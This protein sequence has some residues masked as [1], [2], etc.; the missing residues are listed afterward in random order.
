MPHHA[1]VLLID[2]MFDWLQPSPTRTTILGVCGALNSSTCH[3]AGL[4][5]TCLSHT[6]IPNISSGQVRIAQ[7]ST[8]EVKSRNVLMWHSSGGWLHSLGDNVPLMSHVQCH[9]FV[10]KGA[11]EKNSE[12]WE[13]TPFLSVEE[14]A[15]SLQITLLQYK[16][17]YCGR[18]RVALSLPVL[19]HSYQNKIWN[20][21]GQ[22]ITV[23]THWP[24]SCMVLVWGNSTSSS[25]NVEK[26]SKNYLKHGFCS[27]K[28]CFEAKGAL[29][30][31]LGTK[32]S[33]VH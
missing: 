26:I 30:F 9:C 13:A 33:W 32:K 23:C 28:T 25:E 4:H 14:R 24:S 21:S 5:F 29:R 7:L 16:D 22:E 8:G 27:K 31:Y 10:H 20:C 19:L 1:G 12:L 11:L 15:L 6:L 2:R 3:K 18:I 17:F